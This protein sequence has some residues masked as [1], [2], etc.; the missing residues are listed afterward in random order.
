MQPT[1]AR[2]E[3]VP[4]PRELASELYALIAFVHKN[5]TPDLFAAVGAVELSLTQIKLLHFLEENDT[6]LSVK[7]LAE[8]VVLSLPAAS[9][10]LDD[11][12]RRGFAERREDTDDRR[13]K[14]VRITDKGR[15]V[16]RR[17]GA[18]RLSGLVR[19]TETLSESE[20]AAV[21]AALTVLL[22]RPEIAACRPEGLTS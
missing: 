16:V 11:L 22:E 5:C 20:R 17:L 1:T 15:A 7:Q 13:M 21:D 8:L 14:R 6:E 19:F 18:A 4:A 2:T 9:R 3:V 10:T 12:V